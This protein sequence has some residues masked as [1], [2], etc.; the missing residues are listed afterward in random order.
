M[1]RPIRVLV[2]GSRTVNPKVDFDNILQQFMDTHVPMLF[3]ISEGVEIVSGGAKGYD[4]LAE[5]W[6]K[7][8]NIPFVKFPA[9]WNR[10]VKA[11]GY[12]RNVKM[13]EYAD[14]LISFWDQESRGSKHMIEVMERLGKPYIIF[15]TARAAKPY[16]S[17]VSEEEASA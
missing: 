12:V 9:D 1:A 10:L 8:S 14:I 4:S 5:Q 3:D 11:A 13:G 7:D 17:W 2:A 15:N 16:L 6:A